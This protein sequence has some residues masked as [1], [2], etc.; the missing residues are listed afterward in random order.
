MKFYYIGLN[1][2]KILGEMLAEYLDMEMIQIL[3]N[4]SDIDKIKR[5][6]IV[7][8]HYFQPQELEGK[9]KIISPNLNIAKKWD[10]KVYQYDRLHALV[11]TPR[12]ETYN[13]YV[14][15]V[16]GISFLDKAFITLP[17]GNTG[18][19]SIIYDKHQPTSDI[20]KKLDIV[21]DSET[22]IRVSEFIDKD[23]CI[24]IHIVIASE[25]DMYISQ[26]VTQMIGEDGVTFRGGIYPAKLNGKHNSQLYPMT[27][28]IG[29]VLAQD[30]YR[31]MVGIDYMVKR[32]NV[33]FC[34][35]NPRKMGTTVPLSMTMEI[36]NHTSI[37][38]LEYEAIM[39]GQLPEVIQHELHDLGWYVTMD[40]TPPEYP[41]KPGDERKIFNKPGSI[42]FIDDYFYQFGTYRL[43][44]EWT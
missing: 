31:G 5:N 3:D 11:P 30:G 13:S 37:P 7:Y 38:I 35:I 39:F 25:D 15:M 42:K 4:W 6:D 16:K 27:R 22:Q 8:C 43:E 12:Y 28:L 1:R 9:C 40:S 33:I 19:T 21:V 29:K 34:E 41:D 18:H 32:N 17:F 36:E 20:A 10:S 24:S 14:E 26:P 44:A 2:Y 23:F